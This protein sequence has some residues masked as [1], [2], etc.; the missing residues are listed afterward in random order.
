MRVIIVDDEPMA[1]EVLSRML[2]KDAEVQIVGSYTTLDD[3]SNGIN[4]MQPD[5][6]FLD[7]EMGDKSGLRF[8]DEL[9][10]KTDSMDIVFVTAYSRYAVDAFEV[11]ATDYLL[12]PV[13][14]ERLGKTLKRLKER[15][16]EKT[17]SKDK[18]MVTG[19]GKF[20]VSNEAGHFMSWRTQKSKELFAYLWLHGNIISKSVITE[21]IFPDREVDRAAALL[22]TTVYQLRKTLEKFAHPKGIIYQN[23]GYLLNLPITSDYQTIENILNTQGKNDDKV[24]RVLN[25]Y[26]GDLLEEEAYLWAVEKQLRVKE[27]VLKYLIDYVREIIPGKTQGALLKTVLDRLYYMNP[28]SE[29]IAEIMMEYYQK[30]NHKSELESFFK[31]FST[32]LWNEMGIR[33]GKWITELYKGYLA[34]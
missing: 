12:K 8:A 13:T 7:I 19:F 22:H 18:L 14:E 34:K 10:Y 31:S 2:Q 17:E 1:I 16:G 9:V 25:L 6:V 11:S 29:E 32:G 20:Q 23:D 3:A 21:D 15:V 33:P 28:Y 30:S 27:N 5:V 24:N 26:K 4:E